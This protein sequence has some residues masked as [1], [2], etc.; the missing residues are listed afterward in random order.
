MSVAR[1]CNVEVCAGD[2]VRA[3]STRDAR[4]HRDDCRVVGISDHELVLQPILQAVRLR[5]G[6]EVDLVVGGRIFR[7]R[8]NSSTTSGFHV[9]R[10]DG[11]DG[12][13]TRRTLR[14]EADV[15]A[16]VRTP[17][18]GSVRATV[19]DLSMN[20]CR[21]EV[22]AAHDLAVESTI[23]IELE[24]LLLVG[25]IRSA[26]IDGHRRSYG[27]ELDGLDATGRSGVLR[28]LGRLRADAKLAGRT[29][30]H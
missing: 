25:R 11:L 29:L 15:P 7:C 2:I 6:D 16:I 23:G 26:R 19:S 12:A 21:V 9:A 8:V 14:A 13:D 10:P 17:G 22:P 18:A 28:V 1:K 24:G 3:V 4:V 30:G 20:G 27:V 5:A